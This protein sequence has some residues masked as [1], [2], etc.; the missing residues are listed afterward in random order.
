MRAAGVRVVIGVVRIVREVRVVEVWVV[1]PVE[2]WVV[3]VRLVSVG[4]VGMWCVV[5]R[6]VDVRVVKVR[7]VHVAQL[8]PAELCFVCL[9]S[10]VF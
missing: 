1:R 6:S 5:V 9:G 8:P 4:V 3:I 2:V 10:W 7:T